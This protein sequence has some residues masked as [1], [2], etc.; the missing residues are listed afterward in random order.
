MPLTD[1]MSQVQL[2]PAPCPLRAANPVIEMVMRLLLAGVVR[3]GRVYH[4]FT[5]RS[6]KGAVRGIVGPWRKGRVLATV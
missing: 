4:S 2:A 5:F 3:R 6:R 1:R